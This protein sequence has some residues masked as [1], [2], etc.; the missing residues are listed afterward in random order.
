MVDS[1][2]P[3]RRTF[4]KAVPREHIIVAV[5]EKSAINWSYAIIGLG[6]LLG[7]YALVN[8]VQP[9]VMSRASFEKQI[10][11]ERINA[12]REA[13]EIAREE[14]SSEAKEQCFMG[15]HKDPGKKR[16]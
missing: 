10:A 5:T 1:A 2:R 6:I 11:Q 8:D 16:T 3:L 14:Y 12:G 15:W 7:A 13:F 4:I 9:V